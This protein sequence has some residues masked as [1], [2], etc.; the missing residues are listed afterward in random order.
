VVGVIIAAAKQVAGAPTPKT[1]GPAA[2]ADDLPGRVG[3]TAAG[4]RWAFAALAALEVD[5]LEA[6]IVIYG[7]HVR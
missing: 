2:N 1:R 3:T 5:V 7:H 4:A 6:S